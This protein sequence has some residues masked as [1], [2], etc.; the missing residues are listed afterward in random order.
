MTT[1]TSTKTTRFNPRHG[2]EVCIA[3]LASSSHGTIKVTKLAVSQEWHHDKHEGI[4]K[5]KE[6][7]REHE[8]TSEVKAPFI[9]PSLPLPERTKAAAALIM[10]YSSQLPT[11]TQDPLKLNPAH[12]IQPNT[13]PPK[14]QNISLS[15]HTYIQ[16][17]FYPSPPKR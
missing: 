6:G 3:S 10:T 16:H 1:R 9:L 15:C 14:P 12:T 4:T 17:C 2:L 7:P 5:I 11:T 13:T 8:R